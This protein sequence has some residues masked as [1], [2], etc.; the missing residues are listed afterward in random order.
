MKILQLRFKNLNSLAGEWTIDFTTP[1]FTSD[2]IFAISGPTGAGKSTIMDAICLALYGKTPRLKVISQNSNE[3][4]SRHTGEC[5]SE[6]LFETQKGQFRC[7]WSQTRAGKKSTGRL[8]VTK[9]EIAD[10]LTGKIIEF[11]M[12]SVATAVENRTG[13]DF[14]RFTQSMMLAQG[15]F[16]AFLQADPEKERAPILEQITGTEIYSEISILVFD[17]RRI[18]N[19]KLEKLI[20]ETGGII[21][22]NEA[23]EQQ[24]NLELFEKQN[25]EKELGLKKAILD[26]SVQWLNG[27]EILQKELG[28]IDQ[29]SNTHSLVLKDFEP[30][31]AILKK[32][33]KAAELE[34]DYTLLS[35]KRDVQQNEF[36]VLSKSE[37]KVIQQ[38]KELDLAGRVYTETNNSLILIKHESAAELEQIKVVRVFDIQIAEKEV[39][40]KREKVAHRDL[41]S[42]K[43]RKIQEK[44]SL[45]EKVSALQKQLESIENYL[46][47][48]INDE[49]LVS[50]LTGIREKL[51]NLG[52]AR[53]NSDLLTNQFKKS[54]GHL[55]IADE[56]HKV[57]ELISQ[58]LGKEHSALIEKI[59]VFNKL[60]TQLL[61][62]RPLREYRA[63]LA[64]L[65][66]EMVFLQKIV[67]LEEERQHLVDNQP[68]PLCGSTHHPFAEGNIPVVPDTVRKIN[69]LTAFI[70]KAELL[71]EQI[72]VVENQEKEISAKLVSVNLEV[73]AARHTKESCEMSMLQNIE[74]M[75]RANENYTL[76]LKSTS[77]ILKPFGI[78]DLQYNNPETIAAALDSKYNNWQ[79]HQKQKSAVLDQISVLTTTIDIANGL[80]KSIGENLR[81]QL[82]EIIDLRLELDLKKGERKAHY[83]TKNPDTE[84]IRLIGLIAAA[85]KGER[86]A[87]DR[88]KELSG[89]LDRLNLQIGELSKSTADRK[90]ELG[91]EEIAF[92]NLLQKAGFDDEPA[93][94]FC[95]LVK[96]RKDELSRQASFLDLK[97]AD[98]ET[99][100]KDREE[101]LLQERIKNLT[102][103]NID[104]LIVQQAEMAELISS[105]IKD[106]GAKI[107]QLEDNT[108]AKERYSKIR[109]LIEAQK[110]EF[111]R[112]ES[113]SN[114]IGSADGKKYRN[115]AQGLTFEIM[116]AHANTQLIKLTD[117]YLLVRDREQ[118]L[119]LNVIDN[120]Q[121]GEV[122]STKNLSGGETFIVSLALALGLSKMASKNVRVDSLFL[123]EGFGTLDEDTLET[124]L[125]T[126]A[127][128]RQDGKLIGVI[129]HV[130]ALKERIATKILVEKI[131][132]G[133][134]RLWGPGCIQTVP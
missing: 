115:F 69:E 5:F 118:P 113:L 111:H 22:L 124:A 46:I 47:R 76:L 109:L 17:R 87:S 103:M 116:V 90:V 34:V 27:V 91:I 133:R 57:K 107:Q 71:E 110:R 52:M 83:G 67:T 44:K 36:L 104:Q 131:S 23:E 94:A 29:E 14:G 97:K 79:T 72:R 65:N 11:G 122:R 49:Q 121:A 117:R 134:S 56:A 81:V 6:V 64:W 120:Y 48:N 100:K 106:L 51:N 119:D 99:R 132:G 1:E 126:L 19:L 45:Q 2:G 30:E 123:D 21:L 70:R 4:M 105:V 130:A 15:G 66:K 39:T 125:E 35:S 93:F 74:E 12:R 3:I 89:E 42:A 9:H 25:I 58:N 95:R 54:E 61:E 50:Q 16:A 31:R 18:E 78:I 62:D 53:V 98:L 43:I 75:K 68:C 37:Q 88:V 20:A 60:L 26:R 40:L 101:R 7:H 77:L 96:E 85:E 24:I 128:L 86:L 92:Q 84:E 13:M 28:I 63:E 80:I 59:T 112:W 114:L 73:Q 38:K 10:H 55:R 129:S 82:K 32:G 33:L 108:K 41:L 8:Q 127:S 102:E